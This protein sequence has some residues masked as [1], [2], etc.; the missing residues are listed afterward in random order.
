MQIKTWK[1]K[2]KDV[3]VFIRNFGE[4]WEYLFVKEN[5]IYSAH[6]I[7][8]IPLT[9]IFAKEKYKDD[10]IR[11]AINMVFIMAKTT[12]DRLDIDKKDEK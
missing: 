7:V 5:K 6:I 9:R 12:L 3:E 1:K 10:E 4:V 8:K 11:G 2:Y